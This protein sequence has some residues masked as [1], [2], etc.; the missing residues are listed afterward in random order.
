MRRDIEVE[1]LWAEARDAGSKIDRI[2]TY[3]TGR[4][5]SEAEGWN[6]RQ[7]FEEGWGGNGEEMVDR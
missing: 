5:V 6:G 3:C 4:S 2:T 1:P 7:P